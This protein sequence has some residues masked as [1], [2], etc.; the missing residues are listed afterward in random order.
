MV[1]RPAWTASNEVCRIDVASRSA[2]LRRVRRRRLQ[3]SRRSCRRL[4]EIQGRWLHGNGQHAV[5]WFQGHSPACTCLESEV[6]E[7]RMIRAA[8]AG[9][10]GGRGFR[11]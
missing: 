5:G 11:A 4:L 10:G 3:V 8:P 6:S 7:W 1:H 9:L 2:L